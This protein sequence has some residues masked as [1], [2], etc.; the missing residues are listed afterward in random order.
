MNFQLETFFFLHKKHTK[1]LFYKKPPQYQ[2]R[3]MKDLEPH[4]L[5]KGCASLVSDSKGYSSSLEPVLLNYK[6]R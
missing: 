3:V 4:L 5:I 1:Q 6:K 2:K